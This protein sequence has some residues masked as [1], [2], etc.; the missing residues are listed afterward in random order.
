M[1]SPS[2]WLAASTSGKPPGAA[3]LV[4]Q[5]TREVTKA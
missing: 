1:P 3:G 4:V 5:A 2:A